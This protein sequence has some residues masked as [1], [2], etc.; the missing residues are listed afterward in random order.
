MEA[1]VRDHGHLGERQ[2]N[3]IMAAEAGGQEHR[4]AAALLLPERGISQHLG[5]RGHQLLDPGRRHPP[6]GKGLLGRADLVLEAH[7]VLSEMGPARQGRHQEGHCRPF[8]RLKDFLEFIESEVSHGSPLHSG[9]STRWT[10][11]GPPTRGPHPWP[12][13]RGSGPVPSREGSPRNPDGNPSVASPGLFR[14]R[15]VAESLICL[16]QT[17]TFCS[18]RGQ[19]IPR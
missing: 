11:A 19:E 10:W 16:K 6:G 7:G 2:R 1:P 4:Q 8:A 3:P 5:R 15:C 14:P 17:A 12:P 18:W 13:G 9:A